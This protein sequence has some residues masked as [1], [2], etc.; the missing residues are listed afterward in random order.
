M[1]FNWISELY[2]GFTQHMKK[3]KF[4]KTT[5]KE[6]SSSEKFHAWTN[7][8]LVRKFQVVALSL[9]EEH[10]LSPVFSE[11]F[12]ETCQNSPYWQSKLKRDWLIK[13]VNYMT[14]K[15]S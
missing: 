15:T 12:C 3:M 13:Q 4:S 1:L 8:F 6:R 10:T 2:I 7:S 5:E 11:L 9:Y 14:E